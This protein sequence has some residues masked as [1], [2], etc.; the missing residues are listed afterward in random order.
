MFMEIL[1]FSM[2]SIKTGGT[3]SYH[4][5]INGIFYDKPAILVGIDGNWNVYSTPI[6]GWLWKLYGFL[7]FPWSWG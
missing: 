3:P 1:W 2:V 6:A 5:N 4:P 7:W